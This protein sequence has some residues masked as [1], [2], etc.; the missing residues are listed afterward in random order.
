MEQL[1]C[2]FFFEP[3]KDLRAFS[4]GDEWFDGDDKGFAQIESFPVF[5][6]IR[7]RLAA[8]VDSRIEQEQV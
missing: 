3:T 8:P 5:R 4:A 1:Y 6:V 2:T 7:E